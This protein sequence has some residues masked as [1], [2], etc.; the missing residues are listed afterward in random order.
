MAELNFE[1]H[2]NAASYALEMT[3]EHPRF[4]LKQ[5][6]QHHM[7]EIPIASPVKS[8]KSLRSK[9][10][11]QLTY[12]SNQYGKTQ[13]QETRNMKPTT[14]EAAHLKTPISLRPMSHLSLSILHGSSRKP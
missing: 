7:V 2:H 8:I 6:V 9:Q 3:K 10:D 4:Y 12:V 13:R 5:L 1:G 14:S 11:C